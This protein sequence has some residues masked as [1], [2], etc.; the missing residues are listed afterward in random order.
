MK[1]DKDTGTF[2]VSFEE[3][4][5]TVSAQ[6]D[7]DEK[8]NVIKGTWCDRAGQHHV[9]EIVSTAE[10]TWWQRLKQWWR[11]FTRQEG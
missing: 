8:G 11:R 6:L 1:Y 10:L 3:V 5:A 9:I 2:V 7:V 4:K